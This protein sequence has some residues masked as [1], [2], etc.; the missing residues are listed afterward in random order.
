MGQ[1]SELSQL[2]RPDVLSQ[3]V[4]RAVLP[5][6]VLGEGPSSCQAPG[7]L[8]LWPRHSALQLDVAVSASHCVPSS[9]SSE[10]SIVGFRAYLSQLGLPW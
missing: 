1:E 2:L 10:D 6:E 3:G 5:P 9:I 7:S 8:G 4:G